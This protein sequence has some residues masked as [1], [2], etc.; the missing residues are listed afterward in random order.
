MGE[1][2]KNEC[3]CNCRPDFD[4][5]RGGSLNR[6]RRLLIAIVRNR[7][8]AMFAIAFAVSWSF[9]EVD[10]RGEEKVER[11]QR[12]LHCTIQGVATEQAATQSWVDVG[13]ILQAC[14]KQEGK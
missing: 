14:E 7:W 9:H 3:V 12:I 11:S 13:P 8:L 5:R 10:E 1:L 4:R 2:Q 6:G